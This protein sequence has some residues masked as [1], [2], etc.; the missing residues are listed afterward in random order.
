[1]GG[2]G[3]EGYEWPRPAQGEDGDWTL[4][5][6]VDVGDEIMPHLPGVVCLGV[7]DVENVSEEGRRVMNPGDVDAGL[8]AEPTPN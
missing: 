5:K 7:Y 3:K 1:M 6:R 8:D 4:V 2:I